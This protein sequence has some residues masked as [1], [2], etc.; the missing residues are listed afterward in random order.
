[1]KKKKKNLI[2]AHLSM[3]INL[4]RKDRNRNKVALLILSWGLHSLRTYIVV[5]FILKIILSAQHYTYIL[6]VCKCDYSFVCLSI[7]CMNFLNVRYTEISMKSLFWW[8]SNSNSNEEL[9]NVSS[10][11]YCTVSYFDQKC[12]CMIRILLLISSLLLFWVKTVV[13]SASS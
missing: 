12:L 13:R 4:T 2:F 8:T 5:K 7:L 9:R 11:N 6:G 10:V 1:M 3:K